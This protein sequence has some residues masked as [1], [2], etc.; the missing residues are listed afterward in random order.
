MAGEVLDPAKSES[1]EMTTKRCCA[2]LK[3]VR[4]LVRLDVLGDEKWQGG[5]CRQ[6]GSGSFSEWPGEGVLKLPGKGE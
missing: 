2:N 4:L 6:V 1:T 5:S 3:S